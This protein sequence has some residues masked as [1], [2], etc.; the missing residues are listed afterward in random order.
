MKRLQRRRRMPRRWGGKVSPWEKGKRRWRDVVDLGGGG[1]HLRILLLFFSILKLA[2]S[3][4]RVARLRIEACCIILASFR[5]GK[6]GI[7]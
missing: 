1:M 3:V 2:F 5:T 6:N 7:V 4:P